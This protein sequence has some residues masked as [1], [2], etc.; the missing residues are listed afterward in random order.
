[1]KKL[2]AILSV[3]LVLI[4]VFGMLKTGVFAEETAAET[5]V[6]EEIYETDETAA[7]ETT[8]QETEM[9][10]QGEEI[11]QAADYSEEENTAHSKVEGVDYSTEYCESKMTDDEISVLEK[12]YGFHASDTPYDEEIIGEAYNQYQISVPGGTVSVNAAPSSYTELAIPSTTTVTTTSASQKIYYKIVPSATGRYCFKSD[13]GS[14]GDTYARLLNSSGSQ[15][16]YCDSG[17]MQPNVEDFHINEILTKNT[18]YYL[19]VQNKKGAG[20]FKMYVFSD[21]YLDGTYKPAEL[22]FGENKSGTIN[23]AYDHDMFKF[24]PTESGTYSFFTTGSMDTYGYLVNSSHTVL[25]SNDD[26]G[27]GSNFK[28]DYALTKG[29]AYYVSVQGYGNSATGNYTICVGMAESTMTTLSNNSSVNVSFS[30]GAAD[31]WYKFT[32]PSSGRYCFKSCSDNLDTSAVLYDNQFVEVAHCDTGY[33]RPNWDDFHI[34]EVLTGGKAYYLKV[35]MKT[36]AGGS[37]SLVSFADDYLDGSFASAVVENGVEKS[38]TINHANDH[39]MFKYTPSGSENNIITLESSA[40]LKVDIY[41]SNDA[42]VKSATGKNISL[43]HNS[44]GAF[45]YIDVYKNTGIGSYKLKVSSADIDV[46]S[47]ETISF[48]AAKTASNGKVFKIIPSVSGKY[49]MKSVT[50]DNT[51]YGALYDNC[52]KLLFRYTDGRSGDNLHDFHIMETLEKDKIYYFKVTSSASGNIPVYFY[53]DDYTDGTNNANGTPLQQ[54]VFAGESWASVI[55]YTSD[56]DVFIFKPIISG[57]YEI[58]ADKPQISFEV[59]SDRDHK[60]VT[61]NSDGNYDLVD[62]QTYFIDFYASSAFTGSFNFDINMI[63]AAHSYNVASSNELFDIKVKQGESAFYELGS[64]I[65]GFKTVSAKSS[66]DEL[67][68]CIVDDEGRNCSSVEYEPRMARFSTYYNFESDKK[69]YLKVSNNDTADATVY[70]A[71]YSDDYPNRKQNLTEC[72]IGEIHG[73]IDF[74]DDVDV[75]KFVSENSG[76][77]NIR[78]EGENDLTF[79]AF[80]GEALV[81]PGKNGKNVSLD[82]NVG[83]NNTCY[84]YVYHTSAIGVCSYKFTADVLDFSDSSSTVLTLDVPAYANLTSADDYKLFSFVPEKTAMYRIDTGSEAKIEIYD[85]YL[86]LKET[87]YYYDLDCTYLSCDMKKGKTY[88]IKISCFNGDENYLGNISVTATMDDYPGGEPYNVPSIG[89][90]NVQKGCLEMPGDEDCYWIQVENGGTYN[91]VSLG[92]ADVKAELYDGS[93]LFASDDNSGDGMNF[94][95]TAELAGETPYRLRITGGTA[96]AVG[97]YRIYVSPAS[98]LNTVYGYAARN[99][100]VNVEF[101]KKGSGNSAVYT[102]NY[103][104]EAF[105]IYDLCGLT[106]A[107]ELEAAAIGNVTINSVTPGTVVFTVSGN[108]ADAFADR[109]ENII[110]LKAKRDGAFLCT[111]SCTNS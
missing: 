31:K 110:R 33:V 17:L 43:P 108:G 4:I 100:I 80:S 24:V 73:K 20:S 59:Y 39:D 102:F 30:S 8:E 89:S 28:I 62:G 9:Q 37:F 50:T 95:M 32:P 5:A 49:S 67:S 77:V 86:N 52:G 2:R 71:I 51:T 88:Y 90:G 87:T 36:E 35:K 79:Y 69:Y 60:K 22:T 57:E 96:A 61:A 1:M 70:A 99:D 81:G 107:L 38:G 111:W 63:K 40:D 94:K 56:R 83:S 84:V 48:P 72:G 93:T 18:T 13:S 21:D 58:A 15:L 82:I 85:Y 64:G 53:A 45:Y 98:A 11:E 14:G 78:Y 29:Q 92:G 26:S 74:D 12:A 47:A 91:I 27:A 101:A 66:K 7:E 105:E 42:Y 41:A 65:S 104:S 55:N 34:N 76:V 19:E 3:F 10:P 54:E 6:S 97:G 16:A 109:V 68:L 106:F 25:A 23:Y 44:S 75:Y 103:D 46:S